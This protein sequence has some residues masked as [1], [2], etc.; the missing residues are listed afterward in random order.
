MAKSTSKIRNAKRHAR[1]QRKRKIQGTS[2]SDMRS[3]VYFGTIGLMFCAF[4]S[5]AVVGGTL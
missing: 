5:F 2:R 3:L 4:L 1:R